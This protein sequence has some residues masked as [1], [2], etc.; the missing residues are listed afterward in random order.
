MVLYLSFIILAFHNGIALPDMLIQL[1]LRDKPSEMQIMS[2][3]VLAYLCG[4]GALHPKDP[5]IVMK[6]SR[7][8]IIV[9]KYDLHL[10]IVFFAPTTK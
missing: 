3:K 2:A 7:F 8:E 5:R 4:G 10:S 1:I 9:K 6:V